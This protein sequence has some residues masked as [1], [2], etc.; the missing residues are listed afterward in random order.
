MTRVESRPGSQASTF[1]T[2][3]VTR[4]GCRA[5]TIIAGSYSTRRQ[6]LQSRLYARSS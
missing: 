5:L 1:T 4:C 2:F 3:I 6:P